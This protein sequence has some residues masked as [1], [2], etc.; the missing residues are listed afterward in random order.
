[1]IASV[2]SYVS[3]DATF[4]LVESLSTGV[5]GESG[6]LALSFRWSPPPPYLESGNSTSRQQDDLTCNLDNVPECPAGEAL[7][8]PCSCVCGNS[9]GCPLQTGS[10]SFHWT[11]SFYSLAGLVLVLFFGVSAAVK[12]VLHAY[13]PPQI[14]Q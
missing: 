4:Q 9:T 11:E 14:L 7:A 6:A 8:Y 5:Y 3:F 12:W 1:M 2:A 10:G 13:K